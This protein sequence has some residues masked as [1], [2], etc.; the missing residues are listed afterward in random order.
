MVIS[1]SVLA[2]FNDGY[3]KAFQNSRRWV[4]KRMVDWV[5]PM[6]YNATLYDERLDR[7][8]GALGRRA[9]ARQ[10]VVGINCAGNPDEIRRQIAASRQAGC[11]GFALFAYSYL[12]SEHQPTAKAIV[13]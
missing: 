13:F 8:V 3:N 10:L 5:I 6:N 12:F 4:K 9:T 11:R 7:I 1:A 2:D